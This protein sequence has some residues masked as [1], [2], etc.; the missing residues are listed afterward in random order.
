MKLLVVDDSASNLIEAFEVLTAA[1]H[2]VTLACCP[3][4]L[5]S[6]DNSFKIVQKMDG[7]ITD[8]Y[9]PVRGASGLGPHLPSPDELEGVFVE[10]AAKAKWQRFTEIMISAGQVQTAAELEGSAD[11]PTGVLVAALAQS[12]GVPVVFCSSEKRHGPKIGWL[13]QLW[14][15]GGHDVV[16]NHDE[17]KDWLSAARMIEMERSRAPKI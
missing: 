1:G 6:L 2:E 13:E 17:K 8:V 16:V 14:Q 10:A 3:D 15:Y 5:L 12:K 4:D 7:V 11:N 9:M